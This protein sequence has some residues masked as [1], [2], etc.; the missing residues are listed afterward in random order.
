MRS[1]VNNIDVDTSRYIIH[2]YVLFISVLISADFL[3]F[4]RFCLVFLAIP[5]QTSLHVNGN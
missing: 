2:T 4:R 1:Q 3:L 5:P